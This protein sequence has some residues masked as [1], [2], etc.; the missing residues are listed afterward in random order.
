MIRAA[1]LRVSVCVN[2]FHRPAGL[3]AL[4]TDLAE[5]TGE[6]R[7]HEVVVT[8]NDAAGSGRPAVEALE[9]RVP[10]RL[11]YQI[12]PVQN[13]ARARNRGI[14]AASGDWIGLLDDDERVQP[15]WLMQMARRA[16]LSQA[17]GVFS[18]VL[19]NVPETAPAWVPRGNI[20]GHPRHPSGS[21]PPGHLLFTGNVL[22]RKEVLLRRPGPFDERFGLSGGEDVDLFM[23][24]KQTGARFVWCDEAAATEDLPPERLTQGW[25]LRRARRGAQ[26]YVLNRLAGRYGPV[27]PTTRAQ[28]LLDTALKAGV[29]ALMALTGRLLPGARGERLAFEGRRKW[30][31]QLGKFDALFGRARILEYAA[32]PPA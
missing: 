23:A 1:E 29:A 22:I 6:P 25:F 7:L 20:Y 17:D 14:A 24:L 16:E 3:K 28:L 26:D 31:A 5:Q 13:I 4:L 18:I 12:E 27:R 9:G 30:A 15:D 32:K 10:Y 2:T 19:Q 8:D 21:E 11:V